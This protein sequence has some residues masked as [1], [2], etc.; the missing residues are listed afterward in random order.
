M[1]KEKEKKEKLRYEKYKTES[2]GYAL[3]FS[4]TNIQALL[5][6][7]IKW[8]INLLFFD[9]YITQNRHQNQETGIVKVLPSNEQTPFKL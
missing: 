4:N 6:I 5:A 9:S 1:E 2:N 3:L 7:R 8:D